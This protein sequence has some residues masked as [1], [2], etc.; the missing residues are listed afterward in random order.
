M[1]I[2][3]GGWGGDGGVLAIP[4][5]QIADESSRL[6]AERKVLQRQMRAIWVNQHS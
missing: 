4:H 5:E 3:V 1:Y 2:K 6:V